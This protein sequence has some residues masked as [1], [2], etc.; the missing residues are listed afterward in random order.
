MDHSQHLAVRRGRNHRVADA[1]LLHAAMVVNQAGVDN[2]KPLISQAAGLEEPEDDDIAQ[3][4][5]V[6]AS[7][8]VCR[9]VRVDRVIVGGMG[10]CWCLAVASLPSRAFN[11]ERLS[12]MNPSSIHL[13]P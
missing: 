3:L 10:G 7:L 8:F 12:L 2:A 1:D 11:Q 6:G 4:L 5:G 13:A 9:V